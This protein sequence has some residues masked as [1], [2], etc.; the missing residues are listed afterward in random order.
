M[1]YQL[2][3][4]SIRYYISTAT[5]YLTNN[6]INFIHQFSFNDCI[7]IRK[8]PF[9]FYLPEHNTC[10]EFDGEQ[11][12]K[13]LKRFG[14]EQNFIY[15]Q[16]NDEIKNKYCLEKNI[17]LIRIKYNQNIIKILENNLWNK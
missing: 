15:I 1:L 6:N 7:N 5:N 14:G 16:K 17:K 13:P 12:F 8:L 11:H 2:S 4:S 9:D 3:Y 10:I